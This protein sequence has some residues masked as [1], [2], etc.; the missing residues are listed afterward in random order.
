ML[1]DLK[2]ANKKVSKTST[3]GRSLKLKPK[4]TASAGV[5][6]V[7]MAEQ[8]RLMKEKAAKKKAAKSAK[9]KTKKPAG[10]SKKPDDSKKPPSVAETLAKRAQSMAGGAIKT[11]DDSETTEYPRI[12]TRTQEVTFKIGTDTDWPNGILTED[13]AKDAVSDYTI[14]SISDGKAV[15]SLANDSQWAEWKLLDAEEEGWDDDDDE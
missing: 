12:N 2:D 6:S 5:G 1:T 9:K 4:G 8:L 7:D 10:S 13:D 3:K 11:K 15:F 14:V